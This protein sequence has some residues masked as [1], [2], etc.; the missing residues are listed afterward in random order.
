M[1][2]ETKSKKSKEEHQLIKKFLKSQKC[3][4]QNETQFSKDLKE[5]MRSPQQEQSCISVKEHKGVSRA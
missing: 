5:F 3:Q 2:V 4:D 1:E